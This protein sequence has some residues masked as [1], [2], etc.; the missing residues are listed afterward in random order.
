MACAS[1]LY[2]N[3]VGDKRLCQRLGNLS[4]QRAGNKKEHYCM[5]SRET[6]DERS[7]K[8]E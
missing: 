4:L 1:L 5:K 7:R 3:P 6:R 2:D 8:E